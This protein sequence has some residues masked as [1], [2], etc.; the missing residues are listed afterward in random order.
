MVNSRTDT[1]G[2]I[3]EMAVLYELSLQIGRSLDTRENCQR[4]LTRLMSR[5][6]LD[7]CAVW[8]VDARRVR[9]R[10]R[11]RR[12]GD[13]GDRVSLLYRYPDKAALPRHV[14]LDDD[15]AAVL[16]GGEPVMCA[17]SET[18]CFI[19]SFGLGA[20]TAGRFLLFP[21]G[22]WGLLALHAGGSMAT[23]SIF[24]P[25][26]LAGLIDKFGVS[27]EACLVH[28]SLQ[29]EIRQRRRTEERLFHLA[30][31]DPLTK[32]ANR[33][34]TFDAMGH[35]I[36]AQIPFA[37]LYID[38]DRFKH[39]NDGL[40]HAVGDRVL[41]EV[42]RRLRS[43]V[44]GSDLVARLGGDEFIVLLNGLDD[45][46]QARR[47]AGKLVAACSDPYRIDG[48]TLRMGCSIGISLY[49][50]HAADGE[51]LLRHA[52]AALYR[53]K[54]GG[55]YRAEVFDEQLEAG[56]ERRFELE[57]AL[58][59]ALDRNE[60]FVVYQPIVEIDTGA[61][62]GFEALIRWECE[63]LGP[64]GPDVFI[65]IAEETGLIDTIGGWVLS[66]A[67]QALD[68]LAEAAGNEVFVSVN[69]SE[70]QL[71][72]GSLYGQLQLEFANNGLPPSLLH[73]ELTERT[74][75]REDPG[76]L[77]SLARIRDMGVEFA[78]DDF[79]T[80]YSSL[81]YI[82]R[83]PSHFIKID[84]SFVTDILDSPQDVA[85]VKGIVGLAHGLGREIIAEGVE[86]RAQADMLRRL[87]CDLAQ[88]YL[89]SRPLRLDEICEWLRLRRSSLRC[90]RAAACSG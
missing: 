23:S 26:K 65:P 70:S 48:N 2:L 14:T 29:N 10:E 78:I 87:G 39:I 49:P 47:I 63:A 37:M 88:G 59:D 12:R 89:Y 80:G 62:A 5:A 27:L 18:P 38:L 55:G 6:N 15:V 33:R 45:A 4:F 25:A 83:F 73:L 11:G 71:R 35:M 7:M 50:D 69:V 77:A 58:H 43:A 56:L 61:V 64:V 16:R 31:H 84:R 3:S 19:A 44:R 82:R 72:S 90:D 17:S 53:A 21:L 66:E 46:G 22:E 81:N 24:E 75:I 67:L 74:L 54:A 20:D 85:L 40:G 52:D 28:E 76:T 1:A 41:K 51:R 8:M 42:A 57:N 60:L 13:T 68:L 86:T 32:L 9:C 34:A 36:E 30:Y 79:G